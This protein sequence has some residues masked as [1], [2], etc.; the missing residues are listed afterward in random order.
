MVQWIQVCLIALA[1][2]LDSLV[3]GI[4]YGVRR[5]SIS[6]IMVGI[7]AGLSALL[8]VVSMLLG[9]TMGRWFSAGLAP[10]LGAT[11]LLALG[12]WFLI[13]ALISA[14]KQKSREAE[15][16]AKAGEDEM[17]L[18]SFRLRHLGVVICVLRDPAAA[19]VDNS[20]SISVTEAVLLGLALGFDAM[21]VGLSAG[22]LHLPVVPTAVS[23]GLGTMV[24]LIAGMVAGARLEEE[25]PPSLVR[26]VP[27]AILLILGLLTWLTV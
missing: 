8:K 23:V 27:G 4:S 11:I 3:V 13:E 22:I 12:I 18:L 2:S 19:D 7:I 21:G 9:Q 14:S 16:M 6:S 1:V 26:A 25:L 10:K 20:Q 24:L 5:M 17:A 15:A